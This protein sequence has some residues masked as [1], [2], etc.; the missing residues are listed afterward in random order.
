M[1]SNKIPG[2][3]GKDKYKG[4]PP[5]SNDFIYCLNSIPFFMIPSCQTKAIAAPIALQ[6]CNE[7]VNIYKGN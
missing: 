7:E 5:G 1:T 2:L 6:R 3:I 4:L